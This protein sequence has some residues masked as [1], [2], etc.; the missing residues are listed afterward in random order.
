MRNPVLQP[1]QLALQSK[2]L[3]EVD[4]TVEGLPLGVLG[5]VGEQL[6]EPL[7]VDLHLQLLVEAVGHL[8]LDAVLQGDF[9]MCRVARHVAPPGAPPG[10]T[11]AARLAQSMAV[12]RYARVTQN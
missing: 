6:A 11:A 5:G 10:G 8:A 3:L 9:L 2:Q 12:P 7:V 4:S 1:Y